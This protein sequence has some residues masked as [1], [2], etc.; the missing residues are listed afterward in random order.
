[1][2]MHAHAQHDMYMYMCMHMYMSPTTNGRG[3]GW[4]P[5]DPEEGEKKKGVMDFSISR[6]AFIPRQRRH[7][8]PVF[9]GRI[10]IGDRRA[11]EG[12]CVLST[13]RPA[14]AARVRRC[15]GRRA[16][17]WGR[18]CHA[19]RHAPHAPVD[20]PVVLRG[21]E[22][23][24]P[25]GRGSW[26]ALPSPLSRPRAGRA[27]V[28]HTQHAWHDRPA[29]SAAAHRQRATRRHSV[30]VLLGPDSRQGAW[31]LRVPPWAPHSGG[32]DRRAPAPPR[33]CAG[34]WRRLGTTR[35]GARP[36]GEQEDEQRRA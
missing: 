19:R 1:M 8:P 35:S 14:Y 5:F 7:S 31:R 29:T 17:R 12:R 33:A 11:S 23:R 28:H 20:A 25:P 24:Q 26:L 36:S 34:R 18:P 2:H 4:R 16:R 9:I 13:R 27:I 21:G 6:R 15:V 22:P 3:W 10:E 30:V 32:S